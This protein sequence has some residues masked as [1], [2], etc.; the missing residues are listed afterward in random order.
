MTMAVCT[1]LDHIKLTEP[2]GPVEG[3]EECLAPGGTSCG[4]A[5]LALAPLHMMPLLRLTARL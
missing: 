5:A 2:P 4:I 1:H 3:C